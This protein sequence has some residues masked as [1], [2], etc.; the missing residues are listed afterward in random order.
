ADGRIESSM[1]SRLLIAFG[2]PAHEDDADRAVHFAK[3]LVAQL[4][5]ARAS[6]ATGWALVQPDLEPGAHIVGSVVEVACSGLAAT[7]PGMAHV[8]HSTTAARSRPIEDPPFVGREREL[9]IAGELLSR[10]LGGHG[11]Q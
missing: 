7:A 10:T 2:A 11:P 6:L 1:G 9:A 5:T 4:P 8:D 3:Q